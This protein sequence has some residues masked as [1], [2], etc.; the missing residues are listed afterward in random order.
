MACVDGQRKDQ[1]GRT[2]FR[3][4][5]QLQLIWP[6]WLNPSSAFPKE[7]LFQ[8]LQLSQLDMTI[9]SSWD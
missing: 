3:P 7:L 6:R 2:I 4:V 9:L 1:V 5:G 8:C